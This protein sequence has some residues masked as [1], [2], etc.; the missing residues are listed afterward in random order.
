MN[1][2]QIQKAIFPFKGIS[3]ESYCQITI[4]PTSDTKNVVV[5]AELE[6]NQ[7]TSASNEIVQVVTGVTQKYNLDPATTIW[8]SHSPEGQR[9]FGG[10]DFHRVPIEWSSKA[11]RMTNQGKAWELLSRKQVED[12]IGTY[13]S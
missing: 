13:Y 12:I 2:R 7:G 10:E 6:A 11:Y 9:H 8:I 1:P 4:Y 3:Q 5:I